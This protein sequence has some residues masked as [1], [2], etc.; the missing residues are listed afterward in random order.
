MLIILFPAGLLQAR[1]DDSTIT[2]MR[3]WEDS[4]RTATA[5]EAFRLLKKGSFSVM[6]A[7]ALKPGFT[8]SVFWMA[9]DARQ[10]PAG[11]DWYLVTDNAHI[12]RL[13]WYGVTNDGSIHRLSVTGDYYPF[14]QRPLQYS[15]FVFPFTAGFETYLLLVDKHHE[16]LNVN[17]T[18][19]SAAQLLAAASRENLLNGLLTGI[20]VLIILFGWFLFATTRDRVYF[21]YSL[22]VLSVT[23]WI[24]A[25]KGLGFHYLWP[26]WTYFPS[27]SRPL[28][29]VLNMIASLQ[30]LQ[31]FTQMNRASWYHK[32]ITA[33]KLVMGIMALLILAPIP[34]QQMNEPT[35]YFLRI[36]AATSFAAI[37]VVLVYLVRRA[38]GGSREAKV[39]LLAI[40]VFAFCALAEALYHMGLIALPSYLEK[41]SMF[42]GIVLE[43]IIITFGLASRF[44]SYR[45]DKEELLVQMN[46]QQKQLTDTIVAV[47]ENERKVLADQLHD[48]LGS[49]LSLAS[50]NISALPQDE[51]REQAAVILGMVTHT[52]RNISHQLTPV[53]IE[54]YGFRHATED[55]VRLANTSGKLNITLVFIGFEGEQ[56][57]AVTFHNTLYRIIQELVQN[58]IKHAG[59]TQAL[60]QVVEHDDVVSILVEDNGRG[61]PRH[62]QEQGNLFLRS[63]RTKVAYLE[64]QMNVENVL[65][66]GSLVNIEIPLSYQK[67]STK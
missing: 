57:Y 25:D 26:E 16:S 9:I 35:M 17:F 37:L 27:R 63:I 38:L 14:E 11:N 3:I 28:F 65:P 53:A 23:L 43:M 5:R 4:S 44:N 66:Q 41:Y 31:V 30:F 42:T 29:A 45:R 36:L 54:K 58:I 39:Y 15:S 67:N 13:E 2:L 51:K 20:V 8:S 7:P 52:V 64:G 62:V 33:G 40:V 24:W 50:L 49:M 59:A 1:P 6:P 56:P 21:W 46:I 55:L 22:Y 12:N 48:E 32:V 61:I 19:R 60:V 47:Q 10:A 18:I 34:Y